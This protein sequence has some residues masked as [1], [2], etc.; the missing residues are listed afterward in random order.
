[1]CVFAVQYNSVTVK[2]PEQKHYLMPH[3]HWDKGGKP[4]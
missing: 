1:M 4:T 2:P 3:Q